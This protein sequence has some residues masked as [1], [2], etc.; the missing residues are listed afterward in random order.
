MSGKALCH[1]SAGR[2]GAKRIGLLGYPR[3]VHLISGLPLM[4]SWGFPVF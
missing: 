4:C 3:P 1:D 2:E